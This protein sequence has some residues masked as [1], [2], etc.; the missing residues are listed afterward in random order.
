MDKDENKKNIE[1][2]IDSTDETEQDDFVFEE[3][4]ESDSPDERIK[5]LKKKIKELSK[6]KQEYLDG[7]QRAKAD[8]INYRKDQDKM[9]QEIVKFAKEDLLMELLQLA[10]S[11]EM[12][13]ANKEAWNAAPENWRKGIEYIYSQLQS[14]FK[15][16]GM[17]EI[18]PLGQPFNPE[19]QFSIATIEVTDPKQ[20]NI[21]LEVMK[22]GYSLAGKNIRPAQVKVGIVKKD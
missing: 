13:F 2:E 8:Y 15:F 5:R 11:F 18:N 6:E 3:D 12:A 10:D 1:P 7:W 21:V 22:K 14:I 4:D 17:E 19:N 20:D 9:R 16:N